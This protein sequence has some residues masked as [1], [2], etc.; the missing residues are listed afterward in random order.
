MNREEQPVDVRQAT[1]GV[2]PP[3][4]ARTSSRP[5]SANPSSAAAMGPQTAAAAIGIEPKKVRTVSVRPDGTIGAAAQ[6]GALRPSPSAAMTS[7]PSPPAGRSTTSSTVAPTPRPRRP[8]YRHA[9]GERGA[10]RDDRR[11]RKRHHLGRTRPQRSPR[12]RPLTRSRPSPSRPAETSAGAGG[13]FSVQ[14]TTSGTEAEGRAAFKALQQKFAGELGSRAP[15][16]RKYEADGK[17]VYRVRVGPMAKDEANS[18]C[19]R[20]KTSGGACFVAGDLNRRTAGAP[21]RRSAAQ[22]STADLAGRS[23]ACPLA[24]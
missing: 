18:L 1:R 5:A 2:S 23:A 24:P 20:L 15:L 9:R 13:A 21:A 4:A 8:G 10:P 17:T 12:R 16:I 7:R 11:R 6:R 22:P 19:S 3:P 14:L